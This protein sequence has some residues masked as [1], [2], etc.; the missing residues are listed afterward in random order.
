MDNKRDQNAM[1]YLLNAMISFNI[2]LDKVISLDV[3][4]LFDL[5][6]KAIGNL[7]KAISSNNVSSFSLAL[8]ECY[9]RFSKTFIHLADSAFIQN[10]Y[11]KATRYYNIAKE[12]I[13]KIT[14]KKKEAHEK[15]EYISQKLSSIEQDQETT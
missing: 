3:D 2:G 7:E 11:E 13:E 6:L 10:K 9:L 12:A 8:D 15:L 4:Y 1:P 5:Y 14:N